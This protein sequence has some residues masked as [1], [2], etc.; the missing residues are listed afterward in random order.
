MDTPARLMIAAQFYPPDASTTA[1][2]VGKIAESLARD[3]QVVVISATP[4]SRAAGQPGK[5]EVVELKSWNPRKA[6]I[7]Q[8]AAAICLL[9]AQMFFS[10]LRRARPGDIVFCVTTPFTLPYTVLL[11][12]KLRG[13][14]TMLLIYDLYPEALEAAGMVR[15]NSLAVRLI[16]FANT[17]LFRRLDAIV[18]I[19]R[20]VP[21]LIEKYSGVVANQLHFIPNWALIPIG[22]REIDPANRF[23]APD[24]SRFIVGL[25]GNLGFTHDPVT[26]FE[27]ARLLRDETD[28]HFVLSGW[29][30]GWG[31]LNDL[32]AKDRLENVT[33]LEPVPEDELVEFLAAADLWVIPYRRHIAGVSI[34]SRL[35]NVLAVGRP[36]AVTSE[37]NSEGALVLGE[38]AIGWVV[39][40]EN[41]AELACAIR[42]A[43]RDRQAT[44]DKG[45]HA[46]GVA[47]KYREDVALARYREVVSVVSQGKTR[48]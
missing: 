3:R 31:V 26:V 27:A 20:D 17:L 39:P 6:A 42:E 22:Y 14:K 24:P 46:A 41:P 23:R 28:I 11:A 2:Y 33:M 45:V 32:H 7:V 36:V 34:P 12:A 19:G 25:S 18:V 48:R 8:R 30:V 4:G 38:E 35:Y 40:P 47:E 16:R 21:P 15:S 9:A 44:I 10:V 37:A 13:A 1:V 43:A 5:P 29:G